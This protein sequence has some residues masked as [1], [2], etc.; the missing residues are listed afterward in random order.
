MKIFRKLSLVVF[1]AVL[2]TMLIC[3]CSGGHATTS[4]K[5]PFR[6]TAKQFG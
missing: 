4:H 1:G 5:H 3:S 2:F 6:G